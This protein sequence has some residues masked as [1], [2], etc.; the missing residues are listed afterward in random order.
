ML[1]K[2]I[3]LLVG[4]LVMAKLGFDGVIKTNK[5]KN[6]TNMEK[7]KNNIDPDFNYI[8]EALGIFDKIDEN[9]FYHL[10][11]EEICRIVK[12]YK[13]RTGKDLVELIKKDREMM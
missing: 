8:C 11:D 2:K 12:E 5:V 9:V 7:L 13:A 10:N 4:G 6:Y 3:L 1:N